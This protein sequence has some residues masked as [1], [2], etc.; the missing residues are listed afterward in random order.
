[1]GFRKSHVVAQLN[2]G[3]RLNLSLQFRANNNPKQC[4]QWMGYF[5]GISWAWALGGISSFIVSNGFH[6]NDA[7]NVK[8]TW[9]HR[10]LSS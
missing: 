7:N 9:V 3:G 4:E 6:L 1:M 10:R 5:L 2:K 8:E